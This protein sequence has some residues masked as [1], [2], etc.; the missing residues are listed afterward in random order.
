MHKF[1]GFF[2][3]FVSIICAFNPMVGLTRLSAKQLGT[4]DIQ[5]HLMI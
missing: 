1:K 2:T 3:N 5:G 4:S